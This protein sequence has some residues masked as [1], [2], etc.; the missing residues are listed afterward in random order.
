[1][2]IAS[3]K[4]ESSFWHWHCCGLFFPELDGWMAVAFSLWAK[5]SFEFFKGQSLFLTLLIL[6]LESSFCQCCQLIR[7]SKIS[8][9]IIATAEFSVSK[10]SHHLGKIIDKVGNTVFLNSWHDFPAKIDQKIFKKPL[11][12]LYDVYQEIYAWIFSFKVDKAP[13]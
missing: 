6:L 3:S 7:R 11:N 10:W 4:I 9:R 13:Y 2:C 1:M 5:R 12:I 8:K